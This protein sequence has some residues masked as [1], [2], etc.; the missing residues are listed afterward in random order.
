MGDGQ[1]LPL[2]AGFLGPGWGRGGHPAGE[3]ILLVGGV[4][5][6]PENL[7]CV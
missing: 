2:P 4:A 3:D 7:S 5:E 6:A 1:C